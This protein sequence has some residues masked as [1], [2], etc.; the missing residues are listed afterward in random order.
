VDALTGARGINFVALAVLGNLFLVGVFWQLL[1]RVK[2]SGARLRL[3][4]I[5]SLAVFQ[6]QHHESLY[7]AGSSID[8]FFVILAAVTALAAVTWRGRW[9][10]PLGAG[11]AFLATFSLAHGMLVW[12]IG[13]VLLWTQR[14]RR[15][16][17]FWLAAAA[18]SIALFLSGFQINPGHPMPGYTD[19]PGVLV[20]WLALVGSSPALDHLAIAPWL[21]GIMVLATALAAARRWGTDDRLPLAVVVWCLGA[22]GLISFG[23]ALLAGEWAPITSR[24]MILSSIPCALLIW[25]LVERALATWRAHEGGWAFAAVLATL[26]GF[27][28]TA[29]QAHE[30]A[31]RVFA[32]H[33]E[34]AVAAYHRHGTFANGQTQL[35]PNP[36]RADVLIR[37]AQ[38]RGIYRLPALES[39]QLAKPKAVILHDA[40]EIDDGYYFIEEMEENATELNVRGWAFRPDHIARPGDVSIVFRSEDITLAF[41]ATP[42]VR[43]DVATAYKRPDAMHSGFELRLPRDQLPAGEF[44]IGIC[45]DLDD[46][47]EYMMTANTIVIPQRA[48]V[49]MR[50]GEP[51]LDADAR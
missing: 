15:D 23:R 50:L 1:A 37:L 47:P 10:L 8:H 41:E 43:P 22:L 45:F 7:W 51:L 28:L 13:A 19:W 16:G 48:P 12:P 17:A 42:H 5:F 36:D 31:G 46:S 49:T 29:N 26:V 3:A 20:H 30:S 32:Q 11:L 34:I 38:E 39:L 18:G 6:L 25:M 40:E 14:R 44:G 2:D 35:Y 9:S 24:Y 21:G 4:A 27:N 33:G